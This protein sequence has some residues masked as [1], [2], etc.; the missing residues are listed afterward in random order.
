MCTCSTIV[1]TTR[2]TAVCSQQVSCFTCTHTRSTQFSEFSSNALQIVGTVLPMV[3]TVKSQSSVTLLTGN[4][5]VVHVTISQTVK[6]III[7][8]NYCKYQFISYEFVIYLFE[9]K[10]L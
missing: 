8:K 6:T 2:I 4:N 9:N 7:C 1:F 3:N 10:S 5:A